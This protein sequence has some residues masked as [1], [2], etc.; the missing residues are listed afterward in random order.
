MGTAA[1]KRLTLPTREG[2]WKHK[3]GASSR[4]SGEQAADVG[5]GTAETEAA[6]VETGETPIRRDRT[7]AIDISFYARRAVHLRRD[8][9]TDER[10]RCAQWLRG[11]LMR[12]RRS[13]LS[14]PPRATWF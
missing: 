4:P 6:M 2:Q 5:C 14:L 10:K 13:G 3:P 1:L 12:F 11:L 9:M 7:G 8:A